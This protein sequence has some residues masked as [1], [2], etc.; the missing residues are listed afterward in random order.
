L[1]QVHQ[2]LPLTARGR[3]R[4]GRAAGI[5]H[6]ALFPGEA[7]R[8]FCLDREIEVI[9]GDFETRDRELRDGVVVIFHFHLEIVV[10]HDALS[11][12]EDIRHFAGIQAVFRIAV[13]HP[14]LQYGA[15]RLSDRA[16]AVDEVF[17]D[18]PDFSEVE[19]GRNLIAVRQYESREFVWLRLQ[20]RL[21]LVQFYA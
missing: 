10:G 16:S 2:L 21:Q 8:V 3:G 17:C 7:I 11:Q 12:R 14:Q 5:I 20:K 19:M 9:S 4:L 18:V 1:D 15:L 13:I 6:A